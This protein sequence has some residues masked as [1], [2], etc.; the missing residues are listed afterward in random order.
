[1]SKNKVRQIRLRLSL[2]QRELAEKAGTSQQQIQRIEAGK[3]ATNIELANSIS[4]ALGKPL[5]AVFPQA[6]KALKRLREEMAASHYLPDDEQW[7][8][9]EK[10]GIEADPRTWFLQVLLNGEKAV[11]EFQI[12]ASEQRRLY[13]AMQS[14]DSLAHF[15]VFDTDRDCVALNLQEV[16]FHQ[17]LYEPPMTQFI[18]SEEDTK[19]DDRERDSARLT[20]IGGHQIT[21]G[22]EQDRPDG[23]G[24]PGQLGGV[25]TLL[26]GG[27]HEDNER[28]L[29]T[30]DSGEN[31]FIRVGSLAMLQVPLWALNE[32]A[33]EEAEE[34]V[35]STDA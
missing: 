33:D 5:E 30:D 35:E 6:A 32:L 2:T 24:D 28:F 20:F 19:D 25:F 31:A 3:I 9:V 12:S 14:E 4:K 17:F 29:I 34:D 27:A 1:M 18:S 11:I 15:V 13:G 10:A 16:A 22:V 21:L 7:S 8:V 26:D 23:E